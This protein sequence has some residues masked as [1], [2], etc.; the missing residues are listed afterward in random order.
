M[1][2]LRPANPPTRGRLIRSFRYATRGVAM[3]VALQANARIHLAATVLA[4]VLGFVLNIKPWE[5]CAIVGAIGLVW[6]A[7]GINTALEALT[8]LVSPN[9][10]PLAGRAK[11]IAAGAVLCAAIAAA[12][13]GVIVFLPRLIP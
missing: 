7:E 6:T 12:A 4:V 5:W 2:E 9:E 3:L 10:H 1:P 11:D 8:D 13:I